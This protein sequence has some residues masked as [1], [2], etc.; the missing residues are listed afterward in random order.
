MTFPYMTIPTL[1]EWETDSSAWFAL[2]KSDKVL[3]TIDSLVNAYHSPGVAPYQH[4]TLFYLR[5]AL[6]FWIKK[7]NAVPANQAPSG[8]N[9]N[10]LSA[11]PKVSGSED[12][13]RSIYALLEVANTELRNAANVKSDGALRDALMETYGAENHGREADADW[14]SKHADV[15]VYLTD[16]G[17][18][19]MYKLRFRQ[20]VA[21]RWNQGVNGYAPFDSLN[22]AES[23]GLVG[24]QKVHFVMDPRGRI[25]CGFNRDAVWFK[26]SSLVGGIDALAAGRMKVIAGVISEVEND[27]GHYHPNHIHMRNLLQRLQLYGADTSRTEI[28]RNSDKKRFTAL[29]VISSAGKWP[30]GKTGH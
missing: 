21:W 8:L 23:E 27:S 13:T 5:S 7:I 22:N 2:R 14:L 24:D 28:L 6:H 26:H 1:K 12:R 4:E 25:Y 20:G 10:N 3:L 16:D 17:L 11:T 9:A 29:A 15:S 30:D 19:R 18:R